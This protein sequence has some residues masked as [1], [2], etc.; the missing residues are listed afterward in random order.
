[1]AQPPAPRPMDDM[2]RVMSEQAAVLVREQLVLARREMGAKAKDLRAGAAMMGGA[3]ALAA[4]A[5]GT[6]TAAL[7]LL[8]SRRPGA[9][10]AALGVS[11]AYVGAG[12]L[13]ARQGLERL[14]NATPL[15]PGA[16]VQNA[17]DTI[18][19]S[20]RAESDG[21]QATSAKPRQRA[22]GAK[23]AGA[24][25]RAAG[26]KRTATKRA[27]GA[28]QAAGRRATSAKPRK[29]APKA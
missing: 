7:V 18:G 27:A 16:T 23:R 26:T 12:A 11:G 8:L 19:S 3:G 28:K 22:A 17:K 14:K 21:E 25:K 9:S 15:V 24:T 2:A 20:K 1:M 6:G 29:P 4:L 5:S 10:A 13:L